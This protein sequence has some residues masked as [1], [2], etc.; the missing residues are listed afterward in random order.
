MLGVGR[1][2]KEMGFM[3][4]VPANLETVRP[5]SPESPALVT[6]CEQGV[7]ACHQEERDSAKE[8]CIQEQAERKPGATATV[9][10]DRELTYG[11]LNQRSNQLAHTL[12]EFGVGPETLVAICR[13]RSLEMIVGLLGILKTGGAY[14][15]LDPSYPLERL[16][17]M[18]QDTR[19]PV[20]LT[21]CSLHGRLL[22]APTIEKLAA[23]FQAQDWKPTRSPL[24]AIQ[25]LGSRPPFF[26]VH[27]LSGRVMFYRELAQRSERINHSMASSRK[28]WMAA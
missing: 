24:V 7:G 27:T 9:C 18:L 5:H 10:G 15:P 26:A 8:K 2:P 21:S 20:L 13:E 12:R 1:V 17:F 19:A 23:T 28:V 6:E 22:Q 3:N 4:G 11:E 25:P 14:V 16:A